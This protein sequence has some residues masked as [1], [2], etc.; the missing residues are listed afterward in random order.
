[1]V[2]L[3]ALLVGLAVVLLVVLA[4]GAVTAQLG[5]AGGW[6]TYLVLFGPLLGGGVAALMHPGPATSG[7]PSFVVTTMTAPVV[8]V[9]VTQL[10]V[11]AAPG[12][13]PGVA[14][15][16]VAVVLFLLAGAVGAALGLV[17]AAR[18]SA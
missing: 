6:V 10:A 11:S 14:G 3:W 2:V 12:E 18:R 9:V 4:V 15:R 1:L 5:A 13:G 16:T 17:L 7:W 8:A